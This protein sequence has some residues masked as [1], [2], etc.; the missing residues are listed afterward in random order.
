MSAH[1]REGYQPLDVYIWTLGFVQQDKDF[2]FY[3]CPIQGKE[4]HAK[5]SEN[6]SEIEQQQNRGCL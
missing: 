4:M 5:I 3:C 2:Q 1:R 6:C